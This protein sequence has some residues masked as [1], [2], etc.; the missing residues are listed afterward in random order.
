[1]NAFVVDLEETD[2]YII[3]YAS[4]IGICILLNIAIWE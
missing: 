4:Q 1:M 2:E 3:V